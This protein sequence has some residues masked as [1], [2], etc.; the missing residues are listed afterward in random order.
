MTI[1]EVRSENVKRLSVFHVKP[2][3]TGLV[4]I[5]GDNEAGKSSAIDSME[6]GLGGAET[7][8]SKP[9]RKGQDKATIDIDLGEYTVKRTITAA[10]G[11]ALVVRNKD[12]QKLESPQKLLDTLYNRLTFDPLDF[13]RQKPQERSKILRDLLG[14]DFTKMDAEYKT[15][16]DERTQ[17]NKI[18]KN[19]E[20]RLKSSVRKDGVPK[21]E[22]S[23]SKLLEEQQK[24][25]EQDSK[26]A[27]LRTE[28]REASNEHKAA[29]D[30]CERCEKEI[31]ELTKRLEKLQS[32]A[33]KLKSEADEK[34]KAAKALADEAIKLKPVDLTIFPP[35]LASLESVNAA[36][37]A[38]KIIDEI[39]SE[40]KARTKE[41]EA[42]TKKLEAIERQKRDAIANAQFPVEGLGLNDSNE[43]TFNGIPFDNASTAQQL[44]ISVAM[45]FAMNP[46]LKV[47][48]I[49][50][51]NDLDQKNLKLLGEMAEAAKAQIWLERVDP[52]ENVAVIIEDGHVK[53]P[54]S[55]SSTSTEAAKTDTLL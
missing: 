29:V 45:G 51:G 22:Q 34:M 47:L 19:K 6:I 50:Q 44:K 12:G 23:A 49:R 5:A 10:G 25:L 26:N 40:F 2:T 38:N 52:G 15:I 24:A 32:E 4:I 48:F 37:R 55:I 3:P 16:Y 20:E 42:L 28:A 39:A 53:E 14:L 1:L 13:A 35:Q 8:P 11:T 9:V 43:V 31:S 30:R 54:V 27:Q 46:K 17:V 36:V 41:S 7:I 18:A 33:G 21:E